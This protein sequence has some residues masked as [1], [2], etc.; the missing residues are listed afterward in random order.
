MTMY[1]HYPVRIQSVQ[2]LLGSVLG[3]HIDSLRR[4]HFGRYLGAAHSIEHSFDVLWRIGK[5][6][7]EGILFGMFQ[8]QVVN[9]V[10]ETARSKLNIV[11][12]LQSDDKDT[13]NYLIGNQFVRLFFLIL[14]PCLVYKNS[15]I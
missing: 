11:D 10:N 9:L 14:R 1:R 12:F 13:N 7:T 5:L 4:N 2:H 15:T 8:K 6:H 3:R